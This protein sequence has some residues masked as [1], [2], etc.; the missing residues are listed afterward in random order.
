MAGLIFAVVRKQQWIIATLLFCIVYYVLIGRAEVKFV[1]YVFPLVP[2]FI[3]GAGYLVGE[4]FKGAQ[5]Q[6]G[7]SLLL[8]FSA[9]FGMRAQ[10]GPVTLTQ[11]MSQNDPR[12]TAAIWLKEKHPNK[13]VGFVTDPWF[14][15][16]PLFPNTGLLGANHRL[17]AMQQESS[18]LL[19]Y[20]R[21][22]GNRMD[23][24]PELLLH[25]KPDIIVFSSFEF[26]DNDRINQPDFIAFLDILFS[27]YQMI[28]LFWGPNPRIA[29]P[30]SKHTVVNRIILRN[31]LWGNF[32]IRHDLM[33][34]QPTICIFQKNPAALN[35]K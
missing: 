32:P 11:L 24:D 17:L 30:T 16:P 9:V 8:L 27:D 15:S 28:A 33:Y 7:V 12:D 4:L 1:R 35:P 19:R 14:Y 23:W 3:V 10:I 29:E 20:T 22:D 31:I 26:I 6:K 13:T 34:I 25:M 2:F 18:N 5:W 21:P